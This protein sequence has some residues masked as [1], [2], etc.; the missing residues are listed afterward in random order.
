M[1]EFFKSAFR[2]ILHNKIHSILNITGLAI[3]IGCGL[4]IFK[5]ISYES[6]FDSYH[7][8]YTNIYRLINEYKD[9]IEGLEYNEGQVHPLGEALRNDF[10][11][12]DAAMCF[13]ADKGQINI[14]N[15]NGTSERFMENSGLAYAE[16][17]IFNIFDFEFMAGDPSKALRNKG[18][19][20]ISSSLAQKYFKLSAQNVNKALGR[21][22]TINNKTTFQI[23]GIISGPPENTDLPFKII[24]DYS[25]QAASNPYFGN[26]TDWNEYNSGTNCY[27]LLSDGISV[28]NFEKQLVS[29]FHKYHDKESV[30]EQKYLLQPLSELH[31]GK[32]NNYNNRLSSRKK[33]IVLGIIGLFIILI[34]SFNFI[35][36]STAQAAKR[37]K[38]IRLRKIFGAGKFHLILH[39]LGETLLLSYVA[40]ALAGLLIDHFI[41]I[42]IEHEI[43]YRLSSGFVSNVD[44]LVF[45]IVTGLGVGLLS[46]LYPS[47]ILS[48][49]NPE[50][51]LKSFLPSKNKLG[52]LRVRSTLVIIQL[53]MSQLLIIGTIVMQ[54]QMS[55]FLN[56][57]L[58]FNKDAI[59]IATLPGDNINKIQALKDDF[60]KNPGIEMVSFGT[61]SPLANWKVG[62]EINYPTLEKDIYFGNLKTADED[63]F[64]LFNLKFVAGE[65]YS[66][67]RNSGD[68]VVNRKMTKLLGF[69][70]PHDALGIKF[71][72]GRGGLEFTIVGVVEDFHAEPLQYQMDNVI[73]SNLSFNI[74]E[75]AVKLNPAMFKLKDTQV[76]I[77]RIKN[78]WNRIF[79]DDIFNYNFLDEQIANMYEEEEHTT[80]LVQLFAI[81]AIAICCLGLFGLISYISNQKVKEIGI[82]RVN[83]A[84]AIEILI[85]L[86][87]NFIKWELIA[88]VIASPIAWVVMKKWLQTF[89]YRTDLSWWIFILSA[90]IVFVVAG[91]T[92]SQQSWRAA[93]RNPADA[94]RYE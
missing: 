35:I 15:K 17:E 49:R 62:N 60:L 50:R 25:S 36:L 24:A 56:S 3:G 42:Y 11:G 74:K 79:P 61:R 18:S 90:F 63:Y 64:E 14:E 54:K 65:K 68:A 72:Y 67:R 51:A 40:A 46:G 27:L 87:K 39:F 81:I 80:N 41:F 47:I 19:V 6:G 28:N 32:C 83:G 82:R 77:D 10:A 8:N 70:N 71:K 16:P 59:L 44:S 89:A 93:K 69:E 23:T 26:G 2:N 48:G 45:L 37:F 13:Y 92:V 73:F 57:D 53:I 22:I 21:F 7:K 66:E 34:A 58:G 84:K 33:L 5:I 43:G 4:V 38:E 91:L 20:V 29:F 85:I 86:N 12:I 31:S 9:P 78:E 55:Y 94:L 75:M 30:F 76:T 1:K 88:F 52:S